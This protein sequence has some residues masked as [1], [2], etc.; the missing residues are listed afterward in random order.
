VEI[1]LLS[2][3]TKGH[4]CNNLAQENSLDPPY[5]L[6]GPHLHCNML[7]LSSSLHVKGLTQGCNGSYSWL[8]KLARYTLNFSFGTISELPCLMHGTPIM[9]QLA[10]KLDVTNTIQINQDTVEKETTYCVI[11]TC[12]ACQRMLRKQWAEY[13][14]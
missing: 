13:P 8:F 12:E 2:Q 1:I 4:V 7:I 11:P 3:D 14:K 5:I 9:V 6:S 10:N